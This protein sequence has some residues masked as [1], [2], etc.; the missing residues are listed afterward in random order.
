MK[1]KTVRIIYLYLFSLVGLVMVVI[2]SARLVDLA[3]R[4]WIFTE[5]DKD[6][7]YIAPVPVYPPDATSTKEVVERVDYTTR[8]RHRDLSSSL[9]QIIIGFPLYLYHWR[10]VKREHEENKKEE[11]QV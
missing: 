2:G 10:L 1:T 7:S 3:L 6:Y 9:A 8:K 4:T 11:K 5:A